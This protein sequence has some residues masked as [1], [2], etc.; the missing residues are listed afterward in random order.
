MARTKHDCKD[1]PKHTHTMPL[2]TGKLR[3][4]SDNLWLLVD[5]SPEVTRLTLPVDP[6]L[7]F[8]NLAHW[9][10]EARP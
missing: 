3:L 4:F 2:S 8:E 6:R 9:L 7:L 5:L 1:I 10:D